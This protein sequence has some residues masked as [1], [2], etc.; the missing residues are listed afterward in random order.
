[1]NFYL[2]RRSSHA[3][4]ESLRTPAPPIHSGIVAHVRNNRDRALDLCFGVGQTRGFFK[5]SLKFAPT[6]SRTQD[7]GVLLR[8][9]NQLG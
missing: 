7:R 2:R 5:Y 3:S 1:M 6:G 8:P 9:P 4:R